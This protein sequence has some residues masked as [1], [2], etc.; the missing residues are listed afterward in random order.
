MET[1]GFEHIDGIAYI[2]L[3]HRKDRNEK[4]RQELERVGTG[5][6]E[7]VRVEG[8]YDPL[9]GVKGCYQSHLKALQMAKEK[10][11]GRFA[12]LEDDC[13]FL[14]EAEKV[15][16]AFRGF[17]SEFGNKWDVFFLGGNYLEVKDVSKMFLRVKISL[18]AHAYVVNRSY[19]E[20]LQ[21]CFGRGY[22]KVRGDLFLKDSFM[23]ALDIFW[24]RWQRQGRWYAPIESLAEQG[25]DFS[26]ILH[27]KVF[28]MEGFF[29]GRLKI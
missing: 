13:T 25:E 3:A 15:G 28:R 26:D 7:V 5:S 6:A 27:K 1:N 21:E 4:L 17:F 10:G 22:E 18:R 9:N 20:T 12:V 8:V 2:N 14:R 24:H 11:W 19:L 29:D 23:G 16:K